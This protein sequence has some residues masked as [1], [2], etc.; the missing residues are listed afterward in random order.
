MIQLCM[1]GSMVEEASLHEVIRREMGMD[2]KG[3]RI[4]NFVSSY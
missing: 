4:S 2:I 3:F 1:K